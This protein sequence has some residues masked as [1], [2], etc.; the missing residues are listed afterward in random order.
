[1]DSAKAGK[2]EKKMEGKGKSVT[3]E[4]SCKPLP[5]PHNIC[6]CGVE[7]ESLVWK[8][9]LFKKERT[10]FLHYKP[11]MCFFGPIKGITHE[12]YTYP[13]KQD[14]AN[15]HLSDSWSSHHWHGQK[16]WEHYQWGLHWKESPSGMNEK[17]TTSESHGGPEHLVPVYIPEGEETK[18]KDIWEVVVEGQAWGSC[19]L[20]KPPSVRETHLRIFSI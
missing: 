8:T 7:F 19:S 2:N 17:W 11:K 9:S 6:K 5:T 14:W 20:G 3:R 10:E 4:S 15:Q 13:L 18:Q 1:M 12:L 16:L